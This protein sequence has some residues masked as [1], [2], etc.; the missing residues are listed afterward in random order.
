MQATLVVFYLLVSMVLKP[1]KREALSMVEQNQ[2]EKIEI[3]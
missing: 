1:R 2:A 3:A